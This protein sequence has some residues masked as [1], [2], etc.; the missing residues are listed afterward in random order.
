MLKRFLHT[1]WDDGLFTRNKTAAM[2]RNASIIKV[3]L[4]SVIIVFSLTFIACFW[5]SDLAYMKRYYILIVGMCAAMLL[6]LHFTKS[7]LGAQSAVNYAVYSMLI[8]YATYTS[9]FVLPDFICV[10]ILACLFLF[11]ILYLDK[12]WRI[13]LAILC[14]AGFY[15]LIVCP[16][17]D[18]YY[19]ID[20]IFNVIAFSLVGII[21]GF[22]TRRTQLE[23][24]D[25]QAKLRMSEE[26]YRL[27][28]AHSGNIVCRY[29]VAERAL[30]M[31][32]EVAAG[33]GTSE[34]VENV[35]FSSIERGVIAPESA[36]TYLQFYEKL[37]SGV[38]SGSASFRVKV[39]NGWCWLKGSYTTI[40]S[41]AG[42]PAYAVISF[43][44]V[45]E[46]REKEMAYE[47]W[48]QEIAAMPR[49]KMSL[50]EWNL[51][52]DVSEGGSGEMFDYFETHAIPTFD[53]RTAAYAA[54][55]IYLEDKRP[56]TLFLDRERLLEACQD[57]TTACEME[58]REILSESEY[59]WMQVRV[60]MVPYPDSGDIKA[61]LIFKDIDQEKRYILATEALAREDAMTQLLNRTAFREETA[62]LLQSSKKN[63]RHAFVMIDI[64]NF[65]QVNDTFGHVAGDQ[66]LSDV[67]ERLRSMLRKDDLIGRMGGDE[68]GVCIQNIAGRVNVENRVEILC[69]GLCLEL[70]DG[71]R[72]SASV[73]VA[74]F[75]LDGDSFDELYKKADI[76]LYA[77]KKR[78][79]NGFVFYTA[80]ME[81][82][83]YVQNVTPIDATLPTVARRKPPE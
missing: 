72:V 1:L 36:E 54:D 70:G 27:V 6:V 35:P 61:F 80:D 67:A 62:A 75:P 15:L 77:A 30:S 79:R 29:D 64:D 81:N 56:Y 51:T 53:A 78:G 34:R 2:R 71:V 46:Q 37:F 39:A 83:A 74:L 33:L 66:Y 50:F 65:K 63:A 49:E 68:F 58:Y 7:A 8:L 38:P 41:D 69:N 42:D 31:T 59:R 76:A 13:N 5:V 16:R 24:F 45:T 11:P 40:F 14:W 10:I 47:K 48:Q 25:M 82:T 17:K 28:M 57:G 55:R 3:A 52:R 43:V 20:E 32:K 18:P 22:F 44:D 26:Q 73:G 60:Q 21:I 19:L 12:T 4:L 23:N 9:A